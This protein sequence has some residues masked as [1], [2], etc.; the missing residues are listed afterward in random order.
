MQAISMLCQMNPSQA[1]P[2]RA[3]CPGTGCCASP[4]LK[5]DDKAY[6]AA[7]GLASR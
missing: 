4:S 3:K 1:L 6:E 7:T 5:I 2:I